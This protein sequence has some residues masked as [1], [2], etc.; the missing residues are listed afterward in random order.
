MLEWNEVLI[1]LVMASVFGAL[2][3]LERERKN[4]SAG[5]RTHMLVCVG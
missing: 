3:G 2:V 5:L 4:W 1:R